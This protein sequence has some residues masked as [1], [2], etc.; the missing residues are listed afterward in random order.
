MLQWWFGHKI[1]AAIAITIV[2]IIT[3]TTTTTIFITMNTHTTAN[4][5]AIAVL[6]NETSPGDGERIDGGFGEV[7]ELVLGL[8]LAEVEV[9]DGLCQFV[10]S[11]AF[12]DAHLSV[13]GWFA[14]DVDHDHERVQQIVRKEMQRSFII[15]NLFFE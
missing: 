8:R 11:L 9:V 4:S 5:N 6:R 2:V 1:E 3:I 14:G 12:V 10:L 13:L 7:G 15:F